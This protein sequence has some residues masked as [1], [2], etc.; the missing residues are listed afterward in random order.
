MSKQDADS[1]T[2]AMRQWRETK[3]AYPDTILFFRMGDFYEMFY[4]DAKVCAELCNLTLTSRSKG[5]NPVP[6]AGVPH[7]AC[8][9]YLKELIGLGQKVAICDQLEDH[10]TAKGVVK[11]GVT[12]VVTPGTVLEDSCLQSH[13]NNFLAA[14][15]MDAKESGLACVDL[16]T[17]EFFVSVLDPE[18]LGDELERLSPAET[19]VP[20][21]AYAEGKPLNQALQYRAV[22]VVTKRD[23]YFF[24]HRL[25]ESFLKEQFGVL[26]L[27]GFGLTGATCAIGAAGAALEYIKET[28]P[29]TGLKHISSLRRVERSEHLI[30]DRT[31]QRNLELTH[32]LMEGNRG[33]TLLGVLDRTRTGPGGRL[34]KNWLLRPL[35]AVAPI[36]ERQA[37]VFE[38]MENHSPRAELRE[39]LGGVADMERIMARVITARANA[40][41]LSA[42]VNSIRM[43]P[44]IAQLGRDF[45]APLLSQLSAGIDLLEDV[46]EIIERALVEE[47][48]VILREGR[49]IREGFNAELDE[50]RAIAHGGKDWMARF[51]AT[52]QERSGIPSL[53]IG[54][55][56]VFGYYLEI[57]N[58]HKDKVPENYE[59]KQTL[60]NAERYITPE[61]K[62]YES[63]VLGAEERIFSL[64]Y[65]LFV[66]LREAVAQQVE[67]VQQAARALAALDVLAALADVA[68]ARGYVMPELHAGLETR[69]LKGR[70]PVLETLLPEGQFIDNDI[71][72]DPDSSRVAIITGPNMA[73]KSTYIRQAALLTIMAH[74]GAAI[75]AESALVG[76]TD[77]IFTRVGAADDLARGQSTFMVEMSETA[78]ILNNATERSLVILDEVGRGTSTFDGV[79]LAWAITEYLHKVVGARTLFATH[80]HELAE[81]GTVL[82]RAANY[83][84]AV[85]DWGGEVI[86]LRKI[87]PGSCDR[88]YGIQVARLAGL[89]PGVV[90]RATEILTGLEGQATERDWS[91]LERGEVLRAAAREVQLDL[92]AP[93]K[94]DA[95]ELLTEIATIDTDRLSPLE[96]HQRLQ[97]IVAKAKAGI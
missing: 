37:A 13:S 95:G 85:R 2:P 92:F 90:E 82:E 84:V 5:D 96:A 61:L 39:L 15:M 51:Q 46:A 27:D 4:E 36:Q 94:V 83:N 87:Q 77:R 6:M 57:T 54:F 60:V 69:I 3:D 19:L 65:E 97:D 58:V 70:H 68:S 26:T 22:G 12:R 20:H 55:N 45:S 11:R 8:E 47:P 40:R 32:P 78:N 59:R 62:E 63:K 56:K 80:Y 49:M 74:M 88:S 71:I 18:T 66:E 91:Y 64:E 50:L 31:T 33:N 75:P 21:A 41:D 43:L 52:E 53:K 1:L 28:Q 79:S 44:G 24:D 72:F 10:A 14:V 25:S 9:R 17:G 81:L 7:H 48:P 16:S 29:Q 23:D 67:R 30:L 42:L 35:A 34:L 38:L 86:F 89:P 73:G 93:R 76:L